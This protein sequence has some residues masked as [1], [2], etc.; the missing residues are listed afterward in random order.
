[1]NLASDYSVAI[2]SIICGTFGYKHVYSAIKKT[3]YICI[4]VTL[5]FEKLKEDELF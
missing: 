4:R 3:T 2:F 1:M 5:L